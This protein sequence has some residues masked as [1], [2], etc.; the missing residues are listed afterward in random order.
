[1]GR[2]IT[3]SGAEKIPSYVEVYNRLYS[4]LLAG[5]YPLGSRLP[6]E[7]ELAEHYG[8]GRHTLRQALVIL[9]EDGLVVKQQGSGNYVCESLPR[10]TSDGPH[11]ANPALAFARRDIGKVD[12]KYN[13][14]PP[15]KV[16]QRRLQ[17]SGNE[18]VLAANSFFFSGQRLV[19][20]S[21]A[22]IPTSLIH[23]IDVDLTAEAQISELINTWVYELAH[24]AENYIRVISAEGSLLEMMQI[25]EGTTLVYIEQVLF[26]AQG[27]GIGRVKSY[28]LPAEF[29]IHFSLFR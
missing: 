22:Q 6:G 29:D 10:A 18:V 16:A 14:S 8:V 5:V 24:S 11:I 20:H 15:T 4:D 9:V 26:D 25:P 3:S 13:F 7:V 1:M 28:L 19:A 27:G 23:T 21:F 17:I 2:T 12:I